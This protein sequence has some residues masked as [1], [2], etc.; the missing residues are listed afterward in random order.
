MN[1]ESTFLRSRAPLG[2]ALVALA[3]LG[4]PGD[5]SDGDAPLIIFNSTPDCIVFAGGFPSGFSPLP[6]SGREAAVVQFLPTAVLGLDLEP[7]PPQLLATQAIPGFPELASARCGGLRAD[8]DSDGRPDADRSD[9][10][11]FQ[12]LAPAAGHVR[13]LAP[14]LVALGTSSYEQILLLDPRSGELSLA[15]L[16]APSPGPGFAAADWPFWP[17]AGARPYRSG[18]STRVCVYGTGLVDSLGAPLGA[19]T[20]CDGAREGFVTTF[21]ADS[22]LVGNRLFVATSNLIRSSTAQFSPGTVLAFDLDLTTTPPRVGPAPENAVLLTSGYNPTSLAPYTTPSGRELVLVGVTGAIALG[23]GSG[24]VRTD[25]AIDVIDAA[26][27]ELIASVPLGPAGLGFAGMALDPTGRIGLIGA[28]T[29]PSIFAIDLMALDDPGLG[30]GT[31]PLPILLDGSTPGF[32]DARVYAA[33]NPFELPKRADGPPES[34]C[35]TQTSVAIKDDGGFVAASDFCDGT[36]SVLDLD[37]PPTRTTALDPDTVLRLNRVAN[38]VAPLVPTAVG[39]MRALD[40]ILIRPGTPHIDFNGP[41][42]HFT[43]GLPEGAVCGVRID[44]L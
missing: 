4:C 1:P 33:A 29:S 40:R 9:E 36:I 22:L 24:L 27:L 30:T 25:S 17:R 8:S 43:A 39:R 3:L 21:T 12:C 16:D 13:A 6:G 28:A 34:V 20:R 23:T 37:L 19:N 38:V 10:L 11:G 2:V 41:D 42:L 26:T 15:E 14:D 44:A 5:G 31:E 32:L 35:T 7:E 18:F